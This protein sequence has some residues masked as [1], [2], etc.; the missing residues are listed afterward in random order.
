M[1]DDKRKPGSPWRQPMVWMVVAIPALA[2]VALVWMVFIAAGPGSTDSVDPAVRRTAEIQTVDL[3]PDE[4]AAK[5]QLAALLRID[6]GA[7]EIL[8]LHAGFD[9]GKPLQLI[10][11]HPAR[12][13]LDRAL[14]LEPSPGGWKT[15]ADIDDGHD[16]NLQLTPEGGR[17]RLQGRLPRGKLAARLQPAVGG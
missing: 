10:L 1:D 12:A 5:L 2:V 17:W 3:G 9:T 13:D 11:Q 16:W 6:G 15:G 7:V 8:P 4:N 14:L